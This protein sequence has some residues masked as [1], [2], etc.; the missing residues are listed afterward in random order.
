MGNF[1]Y[2]P[3]FYLATLAASLIAA[4]GWAPSVASQ[5]SRQ[6][7]PADRPEQPV[8]AEIMQRLEKV[9]RAGLAQAPRFE[10]TPLTTIEPDAAAASG[11]GGAGGD[12]GAGQPADA[13]RPL[14]LYIGADF[15]PYCA[16]L[17]WPLAIAL[18]RFGDLSDL[19]YTRSSARDVFPSTATFSFIDTKLDS[20]LIELQ[21]VELQDREG[22]PLS[23]PTDAQRDLFLKLNPNGSI[24][25]LYFGGKYVEVGSPFSPEPMQGLDWEQVVEQLEQGGNAVWQD[26][27]GDAN[28][29]TAA[30]CTLTNQQ[31]D[32]VCSAAG[33][34]AAAQHLP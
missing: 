4:V 9:S 15:C 7:S 31:P 3:R 27:I 18:M 25:F 13:G 32:D 33:I 26:V 34:K 6:A 17:R 5:E 28:V 19:R 21:A 16:V 14:V 20:P 2:T 10:R 1:M 24:P 30:L 22:K 8:P 23:K 11:A 12:L 29:L